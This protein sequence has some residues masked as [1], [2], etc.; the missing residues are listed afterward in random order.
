M[1]DAIQQAAT[2]SLSR[3]ESE[4]FARL[5]GHIEAGMQT[6]KRVGLALLQ[7]RDDRLYRASH[8]TFEAYCQGRWGFVSSRARQL[9]AAAETAVAIESVTM[10]T[11]TAERQVRP[12]VGLP[13]EVAQHVW[14]RA[15]ELQ[16]GEAPTYATVE[17]AAAELVG[18]ALQKAKRER[19]Q[20]TRVVQHSS[21]SAE[22]YSPEPV[23][24]LARRL[25]GGIDLDPASSAEA[26]RTV[27][28][29]RIY[30]AEQDGL[31]RSW[32]GA[33]Y[34]NWPGGRD[35]NNVSNAQLWVA[36][37]LEEY[38]SGRT[39]EAVV[40]VFNAAT[41]AE[42]FQPFWDHALCF[43]RGRLAFVRPGGVVGDSPSHSNAVAYLGERH[44][45]FADLFAPLGRIVLPRGS[46]SE[47]QS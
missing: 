6:F 37:L 3:D 41:S 21:E 25:M 12:L 19:I 20:G 35:E 39:T 31:G 40:L 24:A 17:K 8:G 46:I 45:R 14:T 13:T 28:A 2:E 1:T 36:K 16:G 47:V 10:V 9:V 38:W 34:L 7:I 4:R 5:E 22:W 33:V 29:R 44:D 32:E 30:T 26:N 18:K 15:V 42:W 11:P 23:P 43:P 27:G